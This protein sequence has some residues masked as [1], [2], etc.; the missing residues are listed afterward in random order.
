MR[1]PLIIAVSLILGG[2]VTTYPT[3]P[4][5]APTAAIAPT[6]PPRA[7]AETFLSVIAQVEPVAESFCRSR[8]VA[9]N[10][11]F[12]IVVDDRP[13]QP[14][15]AFQTLDKTNRPVIGFTLALIADARN[16]DEL[17]FVLGHEAAHHISGHIPKRQDQALSG[18]LL[19]EQ[20]QNASGYRRLKLAMDYWC[21][22]WFWPITQSADLPS[23]EQ[24]WLEIGAFS[25][26][27]VRSD[28]DS[29]AARHEKRPMRR[30]S[31]A[32]STV[33]TSPEFAGSV[34]AEIDGPARSSRCAYRSARTAS[35]GARSRSS[36]SRHRNAGPTSAKFVTWDRNP[37]G[38]NIRCMALS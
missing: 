23:R 15:N 24:W 16:A 31:I 4:P 38:W 11:D 14:P 6:L 27:T 21:A 26:A 17:A 18:E 22:L 2:C 9:R 34:A 30:P 13:G 20:L 10:C 5:V 25:S 12:R 35:V 33:V 37:S 28:G 36:R 1:F 32:K 29:R 7:A 3:T 8:G 19:S